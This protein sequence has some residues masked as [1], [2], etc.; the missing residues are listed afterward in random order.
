MT[1]APA[2][3][4]ATS[5]RAVAS[6]FANREIR[7]LQLAWAGVS[8]AI[9]SF[10]IA[11]G[12]Y[13]F[14]V[15]GAAIVGVAGLVRLL[16]GA[17]ASPFAGLLGDRHSRRTVLLLSGALGAI[18]AASTALAVALGAPAAVVFALAGVFTIAFSAYVPAE[19]ALLP[20]VARSPQELSAANV[21]HSVVDNVGF[22]A[23]SVVAGILLAATSPEVVLTAAAAASAGSAVLLATLRPDVR[24]SYPAEDETGGVLRETARG[25]RA[26]LADPRLRLVG[27]GLTLLVFFEG[28]ADVLV[29][30]VALDLLGL[31][32]GSVGYLNAAWGVGALLGAGALAVLLDRGRLGAGLLVGSVVAGVAIALPGV[33]VVPV[34]AYVAWAAIGVGYT[35]VEVVARTLL[36]RLGD[37]ETLARALGF[38]ETSRFAAMALGSIAAPA[39]IALLGSEGALIAIGAVLPLFA[40]LRRTALRSL[41]IGAP[42]DERRYALLRHNS[43]LAP[44]PVEMLERLSHD[45]VAVSAAAGEEVIAQGDRGTRF[46]VIASGEVEVLVDGVLRSSG[47][48]GDCFGEVAM[49]RDCAHTAT[50]RATG[51]SEL[52]TLTRAQ[53]MAAVGGHRRSLEAAAAIVEQRLDVGRLASPHRAPRPAGGQGLTVLGRRPVSAAVAPIPSTMTSA[54]IPVMSSAAPRPDGSPVARAGVPWSATNG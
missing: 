27:A 24:P 9:W 21:A 52:L 26:L 38:L 16:P 20:A 49:L 12:V 2:R 13:A 6:V 40:L 44:L 17:L 10:A 53:F 33:W 25:A 3:Q 32:D 22:L 8:F 39:M 5:L 29:V 1:S 14:G 45:L 54:P 43:I 28:A 30:V 15:G 41:E 11:L 47:S 35:F 19:G 50:V 4:I 18:V 37:D 51:D 34:V 31:G 7:H 36:E 42:A 46:Y 23:G 48:D